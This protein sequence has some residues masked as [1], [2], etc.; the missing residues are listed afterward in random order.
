MEEKQYK[1][2]LTGCGWVVLIAGVLFSIG[3][4]FQKGFP[5]DDILFSFIFSLLATWLLAR[6]VSFLHRAYKEWREE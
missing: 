4:L 1:N 5:L 2:K 6:L 3:I